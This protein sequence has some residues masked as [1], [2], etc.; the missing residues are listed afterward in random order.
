MWGCSFNH[1]LVAVWSP[2]R[3]QPLWPRGLQPPRP[4]CPWDFLGK[5]TGVDCRFLLQV[6]FGPGIEPPSLVLAGEF[7]SPKFVHVI[8]EL[9]LSLIYINLLYKMFSIINQRSLFKREVEIIDRWKWIQNSCL[10]FCNLIT[11]FPLKAREFQKN[12]YFCFIDY[13]KAFD[14]VDHNKLSKILKDVG[15]PDHL[16]C[17]LRHLY[18]GQEATV[19][20]GHGTIDWFQIGKGVHQGCI[21]TPC[22]F[23]LYA[24]YIMRNSGLEESRLLGEIPMT[25]DTQIIPPL[26][27]KVKKN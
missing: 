17:L 19:R 1:V 6:I 10:L 13:A 15:I 8:I 27:Q 11:F 25:S 5:S 18:A 12:I 23:N 4:L 2:H 26:W 3:V 7:F 22:L 9:P 21:L 20:T 14:C 16:N 24:E